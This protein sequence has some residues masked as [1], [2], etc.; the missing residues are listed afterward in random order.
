MAD[1]ATKALI[2]AFTSDLEY[3]SGMI[4]FLREVAQFFAQLLALETDLGSHEYLCRARELFTP[5]FSISIYRLSRSVV[6]GPGCLRRGR[7]RAA[8][9]KP[10][11][12]R[13]VFMPSIIDLIIIII[14]IVFGQNSD[15]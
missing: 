4:V 9:P 10:S 1:C 11:V 5:T 12:E 2:Y 13:S 15:E 3:A 7:W 14:A 6:I 8:T